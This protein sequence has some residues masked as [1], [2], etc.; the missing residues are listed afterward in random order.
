MVRAVGFL[1]FWWNVGIVH[2]THNTSGR[3]RNGLQASGKKAGSG[4]SGWLNLAT[5]S[6]TCNGQHF[7]LCVLVTVVSSTWG[8]QILGYSFM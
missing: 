1:S 2:V 5:K 3:L 6:Q 7:D 4:K 8:F